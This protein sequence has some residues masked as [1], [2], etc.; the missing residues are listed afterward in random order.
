MFKST[1][2]LTAAAM[3]AALVGTVDA[4]PIEFD[5]GL[6]TANNPTSWTALDATFAGSGA[7][8]SATDSGVTVQ[9]NVGNSQTNLIARQRTLDKAGVG[10]TLD[11]MFDDFVIRVGGVDITGLIENGLYKITFIMYD[12]DELTET[13]VQTVTNTTGG[14]SVN[15]GDVSW[16]VD[17]TLT[18]DTDQR[19]VASNLQAD[20]TGKLTFGIT[21]AGNGGNALINGVIVEAV[22]E[23]TSLALLGLGGLCLMRR[24]R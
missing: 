9:I 22:P 14:G 2:L 18:S 8:V 6:D 23:P 17:T 12:D 24:R 7:S 3:S 5:V 20:G 15:L 21:A 10:V 19:L 11:E 13:V 4:A 16:N 1:A